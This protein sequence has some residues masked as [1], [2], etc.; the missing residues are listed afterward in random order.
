MTL[1]RTGL[2][3]ER[4]REYMKIA[5]LL[6]NDLRLHDHPALSQAKL[7]GEIL[8]IYVVENNLGAAFKYWTHR[9]LESFS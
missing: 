5:V 3:L 4:S 2:N 7:D 6:R 1:L 8:P 9:N